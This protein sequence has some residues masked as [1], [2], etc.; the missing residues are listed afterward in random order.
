MIKFFMDLKGKIPHKI[1]KKS[2][3]RDKHFDENLNFMMQEVDKVTQ[4]EKITVVS[5]IVQTKDLHQLLS[6]KSIENTEE[7]AKKVQQLKDMLD[8][9]LLFDPV[10]RISIKDC[11]LHPFVQERIS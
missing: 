11:L 3:F 8:K 10:K 5:N 9:I 4:K 1:L 7:V 6:S 2:Q